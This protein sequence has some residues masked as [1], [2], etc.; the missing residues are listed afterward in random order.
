LYDLERSL[1]R[2]SAVINETINRW[3]IDEAE[4]DDYF[5]AS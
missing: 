2:V 5:K 4:V 3:P 1:S